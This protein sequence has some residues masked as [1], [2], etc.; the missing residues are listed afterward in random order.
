M[1]V[2]SVMLV[3]ILAVGQIRQGD[4]HFGRNDRE[5]NRHTRVGCGR[6]GYKDEQIAPMF[7]DAPANCVLP[8]EWLR[9]R[10]GALRGEN[11]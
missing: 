10:S 9:W 5:P 8:K 3:Q 2:R 1:V 6:A 11:G 7:K 4:V